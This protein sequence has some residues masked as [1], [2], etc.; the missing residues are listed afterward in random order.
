MKLSAIFS[1]FTKEGELTHPINAPLS[2][3]RTCDH[4]FLSISCFI[5]AI[6]LDYHRSELLL[7]SQLAT[8]AG[9]K[10]LAGEFEPTINEKYFEWIIMISVYELRETNKN[11][12]AIKL[13]RSKRTLLVVWLVSRTGNYTHWRNILDNYFM[14]HCNILGNRWTDHPRPE[15]P[16]TK[17]EWI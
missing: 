3:Y 17:Q 6:L 5:N 16:I 13:I 4:F 9:Y 10:E 7:P 1:V 2:I 11:W 14:W 8:L 12:H 15:R